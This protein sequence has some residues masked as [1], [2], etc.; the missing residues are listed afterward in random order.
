MAKLEDYIVEHYGIEPPRLS[1]TPPQGDL[2]PRLS[3]TPPM[4]GNFGRVY[5]NDT[6]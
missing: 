6:Q 1:G 4:E 3:G 2:P 5:I